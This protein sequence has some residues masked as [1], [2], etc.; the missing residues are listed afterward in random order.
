MEFSYIYAAIAAFGYAVAAIFSKRALEAG[1]GI[2]R[3]SFVTNLAFVPVFAFVLLRHEGTIPWEQWLFP[4]LTGVLFFGGQ[5]FTF[6]AIRVGDVSLQTPMMGTKAVFVVI[7]AVILGTEKIGLSM[8]VAAIISMLAVALL[9]FSGVK[10]HKVGVTLGLALL[11]ALFFAGSDTMVGFYG[12]DFGVPMFLFIT[13]CVNALCSFALIPFFNGGMREISS[14]AWP[15]IL[16]SAVLMAGQALLLNY[17]LASYQ[18]VA[19]INVLYT[20]R[21]LWSVL[22]GLVTV[23][24]VLEISKAER[25]VFKLRLAG[26][27][28]MCAAIGIL[29]F[30]Q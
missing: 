20:T 29:F 13:M 27:L 23:G 8:L 10:G 15:W 1:A 26:A 30:P 19:A 14:A 16:L 12:R 3:L 17:T 28:M 6:A 24:A 9:G 7:I 22:L 2:L 5:V 18:N 25:R 21:G 11:S 4:V